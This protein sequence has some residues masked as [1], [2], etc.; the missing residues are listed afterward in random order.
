MGVGEPPR[1]HSKPDAASDGLRRIGLPKA[2]REKSLPA[3]CRVSSDRPGKDPFPFVVVHWLR[4]IAYRGN[5]GIR[6]AVAT[7]LPGP[8]C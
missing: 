3:L 6:R 4:T 7:G 1:W 8:P 2:N 5:G